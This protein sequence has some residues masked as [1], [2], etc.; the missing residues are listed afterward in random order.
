MGRR[1]ITTL[2]FLVFLAILASHAS[3]VSFEDGYL[4]YSSGRLLFKFPAGEWQAVTE[5]PPP[6]DAFRVGSKPDLVLAAEV[7]PAVILIWVEH[8]STDYTGRRLKAY[9]R[10]G[11]ILKSRRKAAKGSKKYQYFDYDLF[12]GVPAAKSRMA[13][14]VGDLQLKGYGEAR[15][16]FHEG[17][18]YFQYFE[19]LAD[20]EVF[21]AVRAEFVE[22]L[23][24]THGY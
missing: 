17:D 11:K 13:A 4:R 14:Q 6:Y 10:L 8:T 19:L 24:E 22:A 21:E 16:Y 15:I 3:A 9:E 2:L 12:N 23:K 5:M 20:S 18:T 7:R 1:Y